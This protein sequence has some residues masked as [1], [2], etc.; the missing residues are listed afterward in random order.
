MTGVP[1]RGSKAGSCAGGYPRGHED[2]LSYE[3]LL[4]LMI[5]MEFLSFSELLMIVITDDY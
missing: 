1:F 4:I 3:M 2:L 5:S